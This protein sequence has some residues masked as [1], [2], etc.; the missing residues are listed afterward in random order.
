MRRNEL[1]LSQWHRP[2]F[3]PCAVRAALPETLF[4]LRNFT[5]FCV[6]CPNVSGSDLGPS[7]P[8]QEPASA[9][10]NLCF[11]MGFCMFA[12]GIPC[13]PQEPTGWPSGRDRS[14]LAGI[15]VFPKEFHCFGLICPNLSGSDLAPSGG[16]AE[17]QGISTVFTLSHTCAKAAP[18]LQ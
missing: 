6:M 15:T 9:R 5:V 8:T 17:K 16:V 12:F 13:R 14:R 11:S 3:L 1:C 7:A 10:G 2:Y 4:S 18:H